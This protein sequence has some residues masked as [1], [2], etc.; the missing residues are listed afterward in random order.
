MDLWECSKAFRINMPSSMMVMGPLGCGKKVSKTKLLVDN[1]DLFE[2]PPCKIYYCYG[3]W[4]EG[5]RPMKKHG[6][7]FH[8]GIPDSELLP[9]WFRKGGLLVLDNLMEE[10]GNDKHVLD[11]CTKHSHH[12]NVTRSRSTCVR[13]CFHLA[14]MPRVFLEIHITSLCSRIRG[15]VIYYC[16]PFPPNGRTCK[17]CF[18][19]SSIVLS[20]TC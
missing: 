1:L 8:E 2:T 18:D 6:I 13:T 14:S 10:G 5:F 16:K 3:A 12:Q 9:M 19:V 7:K 20:A 17:K 11:L 4:Q 15:C